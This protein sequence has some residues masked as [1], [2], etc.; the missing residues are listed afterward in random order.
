MQT[1]QLSS[2]IQMPILGCGV[3]RVM[4]EETEQ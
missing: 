1:T 2:G 4:H 3:Y